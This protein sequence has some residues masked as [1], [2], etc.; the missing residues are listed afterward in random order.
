MPQR[1]EA[2]KTSIKKIKKGDRFT[3]FDFQPNLRN[4]IYYAK[5]DARE[6]LGLGGV[7]A[8]EVSVGDKNAVPELRAFLVND[9]IYKRFVR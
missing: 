5:S 7:Y 2:R 6:L 9:T 4:P 1:S 8:V 3:E